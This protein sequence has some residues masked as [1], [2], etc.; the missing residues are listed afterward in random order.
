VSESA[1]SFA[2]HTHKL[3]KEI[4]TS[5]Q[6]RNTHYKTYADLYKRAREFNVGDYVMVQIR[7]KQYPSSTVK[8]LYGPFKILRRIN[9]N[10]YTID[11]SPVF[12]ISPFVNIEDLVAC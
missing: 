6:K 11:L 9:S 12:G 4:N 7:L 2:Y 5:I 1:T 3:H 8:K 10:A